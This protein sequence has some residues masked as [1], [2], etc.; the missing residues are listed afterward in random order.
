MQERYALMGIAIALTVGAASPGPS[1]VMVAKAAASSGRV[2]GLSAALGMGC[3]GFIFAALSLAGLIGLLT[4]VPPLY[5]L[6]KIIGGI[7]LVYLGVKIWKYAVA[8]IDATEPTSVTS[9]SRSLKSFGVGLATQLSNPKTAVVYASVFAA[10]LP[11]ESNLQFKLVVMLM[12][13]SIETGW[14]SLVAVLLSSSGPR[15][16][17]LQMK[18]LIDRVAGSVMILLGLRLA[19]SSQE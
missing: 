9:Q 5:A 10:F 17:Y 8:P 16:R 6:M 2:T 11:A 14:Y 3:G 12:V 4:A 7:Y 15:R 18:V 19:I 1:F 13:F